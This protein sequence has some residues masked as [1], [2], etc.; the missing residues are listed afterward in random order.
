MSKDKLKQSTDQFTFKRLLVDICR[1]AYISFAFLSGIA[2]G[3]GQPDLAGILACCIMI[4]FCMRW[5]IERHE[6]D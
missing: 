4:V 6:W 1:A 3:K 2:T 5:W